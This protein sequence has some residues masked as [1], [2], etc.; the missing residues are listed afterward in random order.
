MCFRDEG[1][2]KM[3]QQ[4]GKIELCEQKKKLI[5]KLVKSKL[6]TSEVLTNV[7]GEKQTFSLVIGQYL[8]ADCLRLF[9]LFNGMRDC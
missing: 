4:N 7:I 1:E 9:C 3:L 6:E 8:P 2:L 5:V